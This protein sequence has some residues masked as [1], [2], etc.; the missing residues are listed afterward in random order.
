[1]NATYE[2]YLK[3]EN[4]RAGILAVA[5]RERARAI[6]GFFSKAFRFN[7]FERKP[8]HAPRADFARQ[9]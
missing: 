8:A 9:G 2:R 5:R 1:M 6:A 4:F 3:D 7:F